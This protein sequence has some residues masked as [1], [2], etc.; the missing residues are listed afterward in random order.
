MEQQ[1][2]QSPEAA[3]TPVAEATPAPASAAPAPEPVAAPALI[4][5]GALLSQSWH[6]AWGSLPRLGGLVLGVLATF[7]AGF[8]VMAVMIGAGL[9]I[10]GGEAGS[11][12]ASMVV[13]GVIGFLFYVAWMMLFTFAV[14]GFMYTVI[15]R[16]EGI[17]YWQGF[18]WSLKHFWPIFLMVVY[19]QLV[20]SGGYLFLIIPGIALAIYVS[21]AVMVFATED[22]RGMNALVRSTR[23]VYGHWWSV[24]GRALFLSLVIILSFML[25]AGITFGVLSMVN[26]AL[27]IFVGV[28]GVII[29]YLVILSIMIHAGV[30]MLESLQ[31]MKPVSGFVVEEH[32]TLKRWYI[33]LAIIGI[34]VMIAWNAFSIWSEFQADPFAGGDEWYLEEPYSGGAF[35]DPYATDNADLE[36]VLEAMLEEGWEID[37]N[38]PAIPN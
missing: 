23:L 22:I 34:P 6:L 25:A 11:N 18:G 1:S 21:Y 26:S 28:V 10:F 32:T 24:V 38:A 17:G 9:F 4:G 7:L 13:F 8:L 15:K 14:V 19:I 20:T 36:P 37:P 3:A 5:Y 35:D 12:V 31:V 16:R 2:D 27:A 33:A 29:G 30:L